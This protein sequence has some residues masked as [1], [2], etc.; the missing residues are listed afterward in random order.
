MRTRSVGSVTLF[1]L[2]ALAVVL[3]ASIPQPVP[4]ATPASAAQRHPPQPTV[5]LASNAAVVQ[6]RPVLDPALDFHQ[7]HVAEPG[8]GHRDRRAQRATTTVR[9]PI[10]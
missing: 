3:V 2:L 9:Q 5:T 8:A 4:P 10:P 6:R 7:C 1:A